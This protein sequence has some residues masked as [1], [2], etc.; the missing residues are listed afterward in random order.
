MNQPHHIVHNPHRRSGQVGGLTMPAYKFVEDILEPWL[1]ETKQ[2]KKTSTLKNDAYAAKILIK[3]FSNCYVSHG[4]S[5]NL[6]IIDGILVSQF[7]ESE[8]ARG[9]IVTGKHNNSK[10]T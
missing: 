2:D 10:R 9:E 4:K 6:K 1:R 5:R 7:R 3:F 8:L